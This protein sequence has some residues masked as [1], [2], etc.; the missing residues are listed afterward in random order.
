MICGS[1]LVFTNVCISEHVM[2]YGLGL[3]PP[4]QLTDTRT[5]VGSVTGKG[6]STPSSP[7]EPSPTPQ[8][9]AAVVEEILA[10]TCSDPLAV[11]V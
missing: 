1:G 2:V 10:R 7:V 6:P 3:Q 9:N 8:R 4:W 11:T 5:C